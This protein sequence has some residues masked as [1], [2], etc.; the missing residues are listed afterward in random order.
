MVLLWYFQEKLIFF[1]DILPHDYVFHFATPFEEH[2]IPAG[3]GAVINGLLFKAEGSQGVILYFHGN[4]G[5]LRS[6]GGVAS[7]FTD[8][9]FDLMI[10]DYRGYGKS[11][12]SISEKALYSDAIAVFDFLQAKYPGN[13]IIL[14]GR[15]LG[16]GIAAYL[17]GKR[18]P[19]ALLLETPYDNFTNIAAHHMP[20]LPNGLL[21]RYRFPTDEWLKE[22]QCPVHII[23]GTADRIVPYQFGEQLAI[24]LGPAANFHTITGGHHNDLSYF[25]E[26]HEAL[27]NIL[28]GLSRNIHP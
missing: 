16:T 5:S 11:T 9:G 13:R 21:L 7:D 22:V 15:S 1:P 6:W 8:K 2:F 12:G 26:F 24:S 19:K 23:H 18:S 3:D 14:Y 25:P 27:N 28:N 20:F 4:A 17:A 10:I